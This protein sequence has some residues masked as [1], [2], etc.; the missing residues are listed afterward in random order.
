MKRLS[1]CITDFYIKRNIINPDDREVYE[2]GLSL[3]I[4]DAVTFLLIFAISALLGRVRF[5]AEFLVT[6][7]VS[8]VFCGGYHAGKEWICRCL[9]LGTF[10]CT[11]VLGEFFYGF[12]AFCAAV[13]AAVSLGVL[14]ALIPVRHPNKTLSAVQ[15][16]KNRRRGIITLVLFALLSLCLSLEGKQDGFII[17]LSLLAVAALAVTGTLL[18]GGGEIHEEDC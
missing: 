6:F 12:G 9:M 15:I 16:A 1:L 10:L 3:I 5:A 14:F 13:I 7:C 18:N 8:R 2:Y 4:N 17:A 11:L